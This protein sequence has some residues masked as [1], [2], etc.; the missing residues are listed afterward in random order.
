M[1]LGRVDMGDAPRFVSF[2]KVSRPALVGPFNELTSPVS[3]SP[4]SWD[5]YRREILCLALPEGMMWQ[6]PRTPLTF[7]KAIL[8]VAG[9]TSSEGNL[10]FRLRNGHW[11]RVAA[12][13]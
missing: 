5:Y 13:I 8:M 9:P 2:N 4:C 6:C 7:F 11:Q 3:R 10:G 12:F 1:A